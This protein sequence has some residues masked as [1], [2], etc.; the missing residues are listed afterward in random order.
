MTVRAL[1]DV[2]VLL[3]LFDAGHMAHERSRAWW[4]SN[5]IHGWASCPITQHGFLRLMSQP[6]YVG[7]VGLAE[8]LR[9]LRSWTS[10]PTHEF[11]PDDLT[12]L[13]PALFDHARVLGHKQITDIYLLALAVKRGGRFVTLDRKITLGAVR[14]AGAEHL[15]VV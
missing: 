5:E 12:I 9:G 6:A 10:S 13:D 8:A 11:W 14:N 7:S 3:S 1:L 15:V 2:N 4:R